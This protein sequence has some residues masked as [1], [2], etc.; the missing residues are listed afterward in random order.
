MRTED[1][2]AALEE[3]LLGNCGDFFGACK[4]AKLSPQ[5]VQRWLK[6]DPLI[7]ERVEN[8]KNVGAMRLESAAIERA[9]YGVDRGV[10]YKGE[11]IDTEKEY[12]DKLLELLLKK[13]LPQ[14]FAD[15]KNGA[16]IMVNL[17]NINVM[18]RAKSY[19]EWLVM[20]NQ[21][22]QAA[23]GLLEDQRPVEDAEF[24]N[25]L[26]PPEEDP[27]MADIL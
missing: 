10:Y 17:Q 2:I 18:P 26:P 4:V 1:N 23:K 22:E 11:L 15:D 9:V 19:E 13:R 6:D 14:V 7:A 21:T 5:F 25:V 24:T 8:A 20:A 12:S 3:A 16:S 27:Y